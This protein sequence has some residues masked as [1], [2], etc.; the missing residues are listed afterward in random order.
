MYHP[1]R[2]NFRLQ[3]NKIKVVMTNMIMTNIMISLTEVEPVTAL[4]YNLGILSLGIARA[5]WFWST[6]L[7]LAAELRLALG[8]FLQVNPYFEP[9]AT[10]WTFTDPLLNFGRMYYPR[11][12]G[13]DT[14]PWV[15]MGALGQLVTILDVYIFGPNE[16]RASNPSEPVIKPD[17]TE[18]DVPSLKYKI[19]SDI[20][21]NIK[22]DHQKEWLE[23]FSFEDIYFRRVP[24]APPLEEISN[25]LIIDGSM[26]GIFNDP[27]PI[28][29]FG[30]FHFSLTNNPL[31]DTILFVIDIPANILEFLT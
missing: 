7:L 9:F 30:I 23:S 19:V 2:G 20:I 13:F 24:G 4:Q 10:L 5:C 15:N 29:E 1:A 26:P 31:F 3:F 22:P 17:L 11:V 8:M 27:A 18:D 16:M 28:M 25:N 6:V 12:L 14:A 21:D